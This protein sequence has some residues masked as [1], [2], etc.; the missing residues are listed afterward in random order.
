MRILLTC[1]ALTL[2]TPA[3][4]DRA[5]PPPKYELEGNRLVLPA[6][7][8][9]R[10]GSAEI[11]IDSTDALRHIARYLADKD[12]ISLVRIEGHTA[13][14]GDADQNQTLSEQR[15]MR[16][17][18]ALVASGV[19]CKR[20][21]PV[22]FGSNKPVADNATPE[23]RAKNTR[24]DVFNAALRGRMIGGMPADGGGKVAGDPCQ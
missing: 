21:I 16:V 13:N 23:G 4:A 20:L 11:A 17:A 14:V 19:D 5:P 10:T 24:V 18:K 12:Y 22:G 6:P 2:S 3:F 1:L 8:V 15:A 9:F 7:I